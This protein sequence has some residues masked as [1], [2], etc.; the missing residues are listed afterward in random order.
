MNDR[1]RFVPRMN[2]RS[3]FVHGLFFNDGLFPVCSRFVHV[4][5]SWPAPDLFTFCSFRVEGPSVPALFMV[6]S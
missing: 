4:L 6:C 5:F 1:S 3:R 2:D